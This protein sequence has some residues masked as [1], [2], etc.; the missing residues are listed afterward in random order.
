MNK[1]LV[2][3]LAFILASCVFAEDFKTFIILSPASDDQA[4]SQDGLDKYQVR[5]PTDDE[6][7]LANQLLGKK[8]NLILKINGGSFLGIKRDPSLLMFESR[9]PADA[10]NEKTLGPP[11]AVVCAPD[12]AKKMQDGLNGLRGFL[13]ASEFQLGLGA[14]IPLSPS[15]GHEFQTGLWVDL[16]Y[17]YKMSDYVALSLDLEGG[18]QPS[19]N[20]SLTNGGF[21]F[22][23][24]IIALTAK[25]RFAR[26]GLRPY[27]FAGP[28][29]ALES[30]NYN[31]INGIYSQTTSYSDA[32]FGILAGVGFELQVDK[33]I[34]LYLQGGMFWATTPGDLSGFIPMDN[35][36]SVVPVLFGVQ[37]GR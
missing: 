11:Q 3:A 28:G 26:N 16:A 32:G 24:G 31:Y 33:A 14:G 27:I 2:F 9:D 22:S 36:L 13:R 15:L 12:D 10:D 7:D 37:F 19:N 35:P 34:Y 6:L 30:Y 8:Y 23:P 17:S 20:S 29:L 21:G 4:V 1:F 5:Q 25:V 18:Q